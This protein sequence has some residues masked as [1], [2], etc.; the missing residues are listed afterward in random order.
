MKKPTVHILIADDQ[1]IIRCAVKK[2][3]QAHEGFRVVGEA[4]DG[5]EAVI[6]AKAMRP[7]VAIL[8]I[9]MPKKDGLQAAREIRS[10]APGTAVIVLSTHADKEFIDE[11]A[12]SGAVAYISKCDAS[13]KLVQ[14]VEAATGGGARPTVI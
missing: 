13:V 5:E 6:Q 4:L 8:N 10:V 11:A 3:L 9:T 14:A 2:L 7:E 12:R 1:P